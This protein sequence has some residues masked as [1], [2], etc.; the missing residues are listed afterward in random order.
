M[1]LRLLTW[2][3][4]IHLTIFFT[5]IGSLIEN[6]IPKSKKAFSSFLG[7]P[8]CR[9]VFLTP[10]DSEEILLLLGQM[11][12]SKASEPN[13]ISTNL[14]IEFRDLL[15]YPLVSIINMSFKEGAFPSLNKEASVCPIFK[16][17]DRTKCENYRPISLL[18]NLSK[19]FEKVMYARIEDFL[20]SSDILYKYQFGFRK[21][22]STNHALLSIVEQIRTSLDK[23]MYTCGVFVDLEKAFD[24][25][26]HK[27]LLSKLDH[28][29]IRG[30]ANSW[31]ESYLSDRYQTVQLNGAT[32]SRQPITCGVPQGSILGPLL[33]LIYINDMHLSVAS[34]TVFHFADDTNLMCSGMTLK[35]LRRALNK[36]LALLYDWLC[37]N[38]LSINTGKTEFIVFRPPRHNVDIRL[39]LKFH[40]TKLFESTKI[41]YLGLILDNKLS[42][43]PHITELCKKL[44]R[45]VGMLY[46]IRT[47][48]PTS[49]MRSLYFSLFNSHLSYGLVVW[50]NASKI[51]INK[52]TSLQEKAIKAISK[53]KNGDD[54]NISREYFNLNILNINDQINYQIS[55]LMWDYDHNVLPSSLTQC[56]TRSSR[57]HNYKTRGALRGNLFHTKV[58][59]IKYGIKAFRYQGVQVLNNLKKLDIY[60]NAKTKLKFLRD[61]KSYTLSKYIFFG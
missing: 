9:S 43:K 38:R 2:I 5:N 7:D 33:F 36:D 42:W 46:K 13:S 12:S 29:G 55:S 25:V 35:K 56:F 30:V 27:I 54:I 37:A 34:S 8:N 50:G 24:T 26:N 17:G 31:F 40:H 39:T 44:S 16:K 45:A 60:K 61:L 53:H 58:N 22:H 20:K 6:K 51:D 21:Q 48:C 1:K 11:K 57:I 49:V 32:S 19:L 10:C 14:L 52:I 59:T 15:V 4:P 3:S 23:K 28:Y 18:S 47:F 41:K